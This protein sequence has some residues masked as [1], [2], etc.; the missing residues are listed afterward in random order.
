MTAG[1]EANTAESKSQTSFKSVGSP[2]SP[3]GGKLAGNDVIDARK[4]AVE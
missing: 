4:R 3:E 1:T 2:G